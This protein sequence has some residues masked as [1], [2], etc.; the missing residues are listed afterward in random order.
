METIFNV[1]LVSIGLAVL[2]FGANWFVDGSVTIA[3][4]LRISQIVIGLTI[5]AFGTSA[6]ELAVNV[7]AA[8]NGIP[9]V[10]MGNIV[11]SNILNVGLIL[12]LSAIVSPLLV[13]KVTI[14]KEVP[15]M[16]GVSIVLI[17]MSIDG[18]LS[19]ID[20]II[21]V[22]GVLFFVFFSY[23]SSK[24]EEIDLEEVPAGLK[25][26][27]ANVMPKSILLLGIGLSLLTVG[28]FL[29]INNAVVLAKTIGV[30]ER[31]IGLTLVAVGTSLPELTTSIIAAKKGHFDLSVGNIIG[32]NIFNILAI[33]GI[34]AAI[35]DISI[36][37]ET[38]F[39]YYVM[40]AFCLVLIPIMKTG[41]VISRIEGISLVA[42]Y[43]AYISFLLFF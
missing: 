6:P 18:V 9:D 3:K 29:T 36:A 31:I 16:I 30:T 37:D 38:F 13:K 10:V 17:M 8:L 35:I 24:K 27:K 25:L 23:K 26:E 4:K 1:F 28:A 43:I 21:L 2:Y 22:A 42:G 5:V 11:G 20:G 33:L 15:I 7:S 40:L 34:S 14:K 39:D 32:S 12:G 19:L 41:F